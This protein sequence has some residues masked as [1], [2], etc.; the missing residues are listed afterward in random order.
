MCHALRSL[1]ERRGRDELAMERKLECVAV[2]SMLSKLSTSDSSVSD[3]KTAA[4][5]SATKFSN[6]SKSDE[7]EDLV[8]G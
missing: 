5:V 6:L 2:S 4:A 8:V 1:E 7:D 3:S